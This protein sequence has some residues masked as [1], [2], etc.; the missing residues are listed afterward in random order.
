MMRRFSWVFLLRLQLS[1]WV[2]IAYVLTM[3]NAYLQSLTLHRG[4]VA[5]WL[6]SYPGEFVRRGLGGELLWRIEQLSGLPMAWSIFLISLFCYAAIALV[7]LRLIWRLSRL[8]EWLLIV[9]PATLFFAAYQFGAVGRKEVLLLIIP[10]VMLWHQMSVSHPANGGLR[11][12]AL[13][14][15]LLLMAWLTMLLF[16]HEGLLFIMPLFALFLWQAWGDSLRSRQYLYGGGVWLVLVFQAIAWVSLQ[17]PPDPQ[18]ICDLLAQRATLPP[19]CAEPLMTSVSWLSVG[20]KA[21]WLMMADGFT[22]AHAASLTL[23]VLLVLMPLIMLEGLQRIWKPYV[24]ALAATLPLFVLAID[25]GR[26]LY[27]IATLSF[28]LHVQNRLRMPASMLRSA[29]TQPGLWAGLAMSALFVAWVTTWQ[30]KQCCLM[31]VG[32]GVVYQLPALL[33]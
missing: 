22:P 32:K 1:V 7:S 11:A 23:G 6:I 15:Y 13:P 24:L 12:P 25:W 28:F 14:L 27:V 10:A 9:S 30:L 3:R 18:A 26:W 21:L 4:A 16:L 20:P 19:G 17:H 29:A 8:R 31:G 33:D 2:C 5:D